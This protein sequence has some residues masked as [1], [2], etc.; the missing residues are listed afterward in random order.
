MLTKSVS[1]TIKLTLMTV[2]FLLPFF[3]S[4]VG[5]PTI[6]SAQ[7][8]IKTDRPSG[9]YAVG[10]TA[11]FV[12]QSNSD[13]LVSFALKYDIGSE[14]PPLSTG[15]FRIKNRYAF[16]PYVAKEAGFV[17]CSVVQDS[18]SLYV[19]AAFDPF[20]IMP[21]EPEITA[22]DSFWTAQKSALAAIPL[23]VTVRTR[24][25]TTFAFKF[26]F[27]IELTEGKK[28]YGYM[29][30]P[31]G[32]GLYPAIIQL[33]A[34]GNG[35]NVVNDDTNMAERGGVISISLNIHNNL[36]T[37]EGP[38]NYL[39]INLNNPQ[40]YYLKYAILGVVKTVDYLKTRAD[41]NGQVGVIGVSQGAGLA[42]L[43]A[44]IE[45]RI[46]LLVNSYPALCGHPNL[47][48]NK[49]SGFPRYWRQAQ[50]LGFQGDTILK[51]VKYYDAVTAAKRFKG[52]SW[53]MVSYLDD[54]SN[55]ATVYEAFNQLKGQ[56]LMTH[57]FDR[58]HTVSPDEYAKPDFQVGMYAFLRR[59]FPASNNAPTAWLATSKGYEM[60]A[61]R[62]TVLTQNN[63]L[64]LRGSLF[65]ENTLINLPVRWEKVEGTGNVTFS[66]A[67][68]LTTNATFSQVGVYRLRLMGEDMSTV[69][70]ESKYTTIADDIVV[71]VNAVIP[72][73]LLDFYG[74]NTLK[75]NELTWQTASE[76]ANA[77]FKVARSNNGEDWHL[78]A[79]IKGK[80]NT[81]ALTTYQFTD[82][83]PLSIS[84]YR[85]TQMDDNGAFSYSK[86]ISL[87][88]HT[89]P[90]L[91]IFPNPVHQLLTL[92]TNVS[93]PIAYR[94]YDVLGRLCV[95]KTLFSAINTVDT[96]DLLRGLYFIQIQS[97]EGNVVKQFI[98]Q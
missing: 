80:G 81:T 75:G 26:G 40:N 1:F 89:S 83:D 79:D 61:G 55:A 84:Y 6:L 20:K 14:L 78:L 73:E 36:P 33:P 4:L 62:D 29:T 10:D 87:S 66:N 68:S 7:L 2:K 41:F 47:K 64:I 91:D 52:V 13:S 21:I 16:I 94:I 71:T 82:A 49:P 5:V 95:S 53:T 85:L 37:Q 34:F 60:D 19:G 42:I 56:K 65:L 92:K 96:S 32:N 88:T 98:K 48:Y 97:K 50:A 63:A 28:V 86:I 39:N 77:G 45:P 58:G 22:F 67:Q 8:S 11:F 74:K 18:Q 70:T 35:P 15:Q 23:R 30:S 17:H 59:H 76:K 31:R 25:T 24:D 72:V 93:L 38:V 69:T 44:G 51:T 9:R 12:V 3:F 57:V 46:S 90:F 54:V 27:D 43:A